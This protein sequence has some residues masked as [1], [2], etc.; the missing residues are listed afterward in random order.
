MA[1]TAKDYASP[2]KPT[3]CPGCGHFTALNGLYEAAERLQ[4]QPKDF[5]LV[6]GIGCSGRFPFFAKGFGVHSL[7]GRAVPLATGIKIA[8]PN[9][10]VVVVGNL[11]R[12]S[13]G[14][15]ALHKGE[16]QEMLETVG[17]Q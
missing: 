17:Q 8:N 14:G 6:S 5:V 3:W 4:I 10:T 16:Q 1:V 2:V 15:G 9:L 12:L 13:G 7:H 11:S